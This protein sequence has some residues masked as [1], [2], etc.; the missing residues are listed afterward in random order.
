MQAEPLARMALDRSHPL[1][2]FLG[3]VLSLSALINLSQHLV[4]LLGVGDFV[5]VEQCFVRPAYSVFLV[6][7][8]TEKERTPCSP[9][10]TL[11]KEAHACNS[12]A[13]RCIEDGKV[14]IRSTRGLVMSRLMESMA[15][16]P[17]IM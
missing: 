6:S 17:I 4:F 16:E 11:T 14:C 13:T 12:S 5:L 10:R 1:Y 3:G 8:H 15:D 7:A 9:E 2:C